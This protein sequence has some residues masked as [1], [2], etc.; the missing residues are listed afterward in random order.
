MDFVV[1]EKDARGND[2]GGG[3]LMYFALWLFVSWWKAREREGRAMGNEYGVVFRGLR[4]TT[5][6]RN[7]D[8][9]IGQFRRVVS[10]DWREAVRWHTCDCDEV[11]AHLTAHRIKFF[12]FSFFLIGSCVCGNMEGCEN[13]CA[14][15]KCNTCRR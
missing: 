11:V 8:C 15:E 2:G 10:I 6:C 4:R 12:S 9:S 3:K 14:R 1:R 13:Q 7:A 5:T